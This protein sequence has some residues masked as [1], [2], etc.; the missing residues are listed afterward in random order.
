VP[1]RKSNHAHAHNPASAT[2]VD[3][4]HLDYLRVLSKKSRSSAHLWN[5]SFVEM[6]SATVVASRCGTSQ[7]RAT[8]ACDTSALVE[9]R[10]PK[11][12]HTR[13]IAPL[14]PS[15]PPRCDRPIRQILKIVFNSPDRVLRFTVDRAFVGRG[16]AFGAV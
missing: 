11:D 2:A 15:D 3:D 4:S 9:G 5:D 10:S 13:S 1:Q 8:A 14:S 12:G 6:C 7:S 16:A